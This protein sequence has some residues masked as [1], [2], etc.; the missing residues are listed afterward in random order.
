M[1]KMLRNSTQASVISL[2]CTTT[3]FLSLTAELPIKLK[4][5]VLLAVLICAAD[6]ASFTAAAIAVTK[7]RLPSK[8]DLN[9]S[10][11]TGLILG[12]SITRTIMQSLELPVPGL[13]SLQVISALILLIVAVTSSV[14][15]SDFSH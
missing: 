2:F 6:F 15:V 7:K 3:A 11:L 8:R 10:V 9:Y 14:L 13:L 4:L 12:V 5:G 1:V